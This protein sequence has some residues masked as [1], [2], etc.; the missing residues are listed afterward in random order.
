[1]AEFLIKAIDAHHPAD[2][3]KDAG[4][5]Y[6][7]GDVVVVMPD[8]HGWGKEERLPKFVVIKIPGLGVK[9]AKKYTEIEPDLSDPEGHRV[10]RRRRYTM[11]LNNLPAQIKQSLNKD[12][13][14]SITFDQAKRCI[15]NVS[16]GIVER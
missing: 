16:L 6:K 14:A 2:L 7:R 12:G 3:I 13:E 1:M 15:K 5:C 8:G 4:G 9:E 10:K 11:L